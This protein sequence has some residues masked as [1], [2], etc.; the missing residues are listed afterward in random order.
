L[1]GVTLIDFL[2]SRPDAPEEEVVEEE[3]PAEEVEEAAIL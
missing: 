1:G 3:A 2:G